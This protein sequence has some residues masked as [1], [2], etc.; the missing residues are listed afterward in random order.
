MNSKNFDSIFG[1]QNKNS[2]VPHWIESIFAEG[3]YGNIIEDKEIRKEI[4]GIGIGLRKE[5][6]P[7]SFVDE[8]IYKKIVK[9]IN[10]KLKNISKDELIYVLGDI[11]DVAGIIDEY[12]TK[13]ISTYK[14]IIQNEPE[15]LEFE[16]DDDRDIVQERS[17]N[18]EKEASDIKYIREDLRDAK[19]EL[20]ELK[21][22]L[23]REKDTEKKITYRKRIKEL[24]DD[25]RDLKK[26]RNEIKSNEDKKEI[27]S[28]NENNIDIENKQANYNKLWKEIQDVEYDI[29]HTTDQNK[30]EN[31]KNYL[32]KLK[33]VYELDKVSNIDVKKKATLEDEPYSLKDRVKLNS[34]FANLKTNVQGTIDKIGPGYIIITTD[35]NRSFK[36]GQEDLQYLDKIMS[37][38][39]LESLKNKEPGNRLITEEGHPAIVLEVVRDIDQ[40]PIALK[41]WNFRSQKDETIDI[42]YSPTEKANID[43]MDNI[44]EQE[45]QEE[46]IEPAPLPEEGETFHAYINNVINKQSKRYSVQYKKEESENWRETDSYS[47]IENAKAE[48]DRLEESYSDEVR[49]FDTQTDKII[50]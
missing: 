45:E 4:E 43:V 50:E 29:E 9:W 3:E 13:I 33:D 30:V 15:A 26:K 42:P 17:E 38:E 31:L 36:F 22:E 47:D 21:Q 12:Q 44:E 2:S 49:I 1:S 5:F 18:I 8:S 24:K 39:Y 35:D 40:E 27:E 16:S 25:I 41:I 7:E 48:K 32:N 14:K 11:L 34:D 37:G 20:E 23:L 10:S 46:N 28:N 6:L 19:Q